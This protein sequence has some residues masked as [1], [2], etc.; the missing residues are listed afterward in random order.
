MDRCALYAARY[1]AAACRH[2]GCDGGDHIPLPCLAC[3]RP[4]KYIP[5]GEL[6]VQCWFQ[7]NCHHGCALVALCMQQQDSVCAS[8]RSCSM[9]AEDCCGGQRADATGRTWAPPLGKCLHLPDLA[10]SVL[11]YLNDANVMLGHSCCPH[12]LSLAL[13]LFRSQGSRLAVGGSPLPRHA[14]E[15][16]GIDKGA[17]LWHSACRTTGR[18]LHANVGAAAHATVDPRADAILQF[19]WACHG[20]QTHSGC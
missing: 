13:G 19:W 4:P 20:A 6:C 11:E 15:L 18:R 8:A 10:L 3:S 2:A 1:P 7:Q 9:Q 17:L 12:T 14:H 5:S 16:I